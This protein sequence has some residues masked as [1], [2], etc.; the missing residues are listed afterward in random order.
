[1][2]YM[3]TLQHKSP[4]YGDLEIYNIQNL[5]HFSLVIFIFSSN[6]LLFF[7]KYRKLLILIT[8]GSHSNSKRPEGKP[9]PHI[10]YV[11]RM[12]KTI[13]LIFVSKQTTEERI[14]LTHF[15]EIKQHIIARFIKKNY[16]FSSIN[17]YLNK[18]TYTAEELRAL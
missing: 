2:T 7:F 4:C 18:I 11:K 13:Q 6:T 12:W 3:I 1:M 10:T 14:V 5:L 17:L 15:N 16:Q 8:R 9:F